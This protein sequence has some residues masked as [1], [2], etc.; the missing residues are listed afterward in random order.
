MKF[1]PR[2][3][4]PPGNP[5]EEEQE[6]NAMAGLGPEVGDYLRDFSNSP[7]DEADEPEPEREFITNVAEAVTEVISIPADAWLVLPHTV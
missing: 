5:R 3:G 7:A 1:G 2:R 6:G 4:N